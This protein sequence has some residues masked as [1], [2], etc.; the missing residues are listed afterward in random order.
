MFPPPFSFKYVAYGETG[1]QLV[2]GHLKQEKTDLE[3]RSTDWLRDV[4]FVAE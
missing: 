4:T 2:Q 3:G 1:R